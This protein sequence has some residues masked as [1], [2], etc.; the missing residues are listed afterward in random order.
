[1][2]LVNTRSMKMCHRVV[3]GVSSIPM[4]LGNFKDVTHA[5]IRI[6]DIVGGAIAMSFGTKNSRPARVRSPGLEARINRCKNLALYIRDCESLCL[7]DE[8]VKAV[9]LFYLVSMP[10]EVKYPTQGVN[11]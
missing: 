4:V 10:G 9:G 6:T 3:C 2:R 7:L 1:M 8:K 5:R 11:V